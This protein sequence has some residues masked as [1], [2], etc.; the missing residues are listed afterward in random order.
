MT[1]K[2][3]IWFAVFL[4]MFA[5]PEVLWSP[6]SNVIFGLLKDMPYR[7]NLLTGT[8]NKDLMVF[9]VFVQ[10][11]GTSGMSSFLLFKKMYRNIKEGRAIFGLSL[12]FS[13]AVLFALYILLSTVNM[14]F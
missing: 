5:V 6:V 1:K 4:A 10:F 11:L 7:D 8:D 14:S 9:T 12:F 3:K 2:Q 13:L